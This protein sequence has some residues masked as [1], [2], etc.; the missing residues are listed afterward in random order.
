MSQQVEDGAAAQPTG[1]ETP[2]Y[3]QTDEELQECSKYSLEVA[4]PASLF[5]PDPRASVFPL[6][7]YQSNLALEGCPKSS[8]AA[9][10]AIPADGSCAS[11]LN[12]PVLPFTIWEGAYDDVGKENIDPITKKNGKRRKQRAGAKD[13]K[14]RKR[15]VL[16]DI[17]PKCRST[18]VTG[19]SKKRAKAKVI[20]LKTSYSKPLLSVR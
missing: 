13:R 8:A 10:A 4:R 5:S 19:K 6:N 1:F 9:T 3:H 12:V 18:K 20:G 7:L 15:R 16:G 17:T 2:I 11:N 14:G